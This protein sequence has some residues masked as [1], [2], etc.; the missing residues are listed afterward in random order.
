MYVKVQW[1]LGVE[2]ASPSSTS[3]VISLFTHNNFCGF[4]LCHFLYVAIKFCTFMSR[5]LNLTG[6]V[7]RHTRRYI[8][9][10]VAV[11]NKV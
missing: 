6:N 4:S 10:E 5:I 7:T 3:V 9:A 2:I 8:F 1:W 11:T